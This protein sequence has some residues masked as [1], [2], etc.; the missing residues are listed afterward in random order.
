MKLKR[1]LTVLIIALFVLVVTFSFFGIFSIRKVETTFSVSENTAVEKLQ[2]KFDALLNKN[3][4][5]L[6]EQEI[7]DCLKDNHYMEI[8]SVEKSFPNVVKVNVK[9][10]REIYYLECPNGYLVTTTDGFV[11]RTV[12]TV[13]SGERDKIV[14]SLDGISLLDGTI[15]KVVKTD[16]DQLLKLVFEMAKSVNLTD[17]I[18]E[19][20]VFTMGGES[21]D[22][23]FGIYTG[24]DI[25]VQ[26][27]DE[28][29]VQKAIEGFSAYD[30]HAN[31]YEK[32]FKNIL[33][34][35]TADGKIQATWSEQK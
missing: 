19:I 13:P 14:L 26:K 7:Y 22:V 31:D 8:L 10:R 29:G 16:N 15:G 23:T 34:N 12:S 1:S 17:C 18:E 33:V 28:D 35:K 24:V 27:A 32:M 11:L 3:L 21:A 9:E 6:D 2:E 25:V 30:T 5:F 20:T 4:L